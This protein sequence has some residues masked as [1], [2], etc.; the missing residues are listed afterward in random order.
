MRTATFLV[1]PAE[2]TR[3]PLGTHNLH[4]D[5]RKMN[6]AHDL[7]TRFDLSTR[8]DRFGVSVAISGDTAVICAGAT[9]LLRRNDF[10]S[11]GHAEQQA[12]LSTLL[13]ED[14]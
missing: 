9:A 1:F 10:R 3:V 2:P 11:R 4:E 8:F 12:A 5:L 7:V 13:E 14:T 6:P